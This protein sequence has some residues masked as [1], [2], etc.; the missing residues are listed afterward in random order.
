[1]QGD[2]HGALRAARK[3]VCR[4]NSGCIAAGWRGQLCSHRRRALVFLPMVPAVS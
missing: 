3:G 4:G 1:M 2:I